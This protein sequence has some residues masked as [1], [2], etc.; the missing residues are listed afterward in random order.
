MAFSWF[1][2]PF[3]PRWVNSPAYGHPTH[4]DVRPFSFFDWFSSF[5][6]SMVIHNDMATPASSVV[7]SGG[8]KSP[9][10]LASRLTCKICGATFVYPGSF[11]KH[12]QRHEMS[13]KRNQESTSS[14]GVSSPLALPTASMALACQ[15][16]LQQVAPQPVVS[17]STSTSM[18]HGY[19]ANSRGKYDVI[20]DNRHLI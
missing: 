8:G 19:F 9:A 16:G 13:N 11:T 12:M 6:F 14:A 4:S 15:K 10:S 20:D 17:P 5:Q 2:P 1:T 18:T 3:Y 7:T